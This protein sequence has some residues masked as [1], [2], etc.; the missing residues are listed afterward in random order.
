MTANRQLLLSARPSGLCKPGDLVLG[1]SQLPELQDGQALAQVRF[2]SID[3]TMRV[4]MGERDSYLPAIP[5]GNVMRCFGLGEILESKNSEFQRGEKVVG[6]VGMQEYAVIGAKEARGFQRV[7]AIP[8]IPESAFLGVL[9]V[10]GITA[11]FGMTD[12]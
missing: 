2:L 3:P 8:L 6:L 12:V 5:L 10:T 9:G 11:Y 4:W 1:E 7:P